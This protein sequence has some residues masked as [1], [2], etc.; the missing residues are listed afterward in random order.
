MNDRRHNL[1][2]LSRGT[3]RSVGSS[4][5]KGV[6][7]I[8]AVYTAP[9]GTAIR[10][11]P[12]IEK[13]PRLLSADCPGD[14]PCHDTCPGL[15]CGGRSPLPHFSGNCSGNECT[16]EWCLSGECGVDCLEVVEP[17]PSK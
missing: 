16:L 10:P 1:F 17:C 14:C 11:L 12:V 15:T 3:A 8:T 2:T 6:E 13:Y 7:G 9:A 5:K 4:G